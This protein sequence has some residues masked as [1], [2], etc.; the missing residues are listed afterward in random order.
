MLTWTVPTVSS[1]SATSSIHSVNKLKGKRHFA[2]GQDAKRSFLWSRRW[3]DRARRWLMHSIFNMLVR[4]LL[5]NNC[6][7]WRGDREQK[8]KYRLMCHQILSTSLPRN[9]SSRWHMEQNQSSFPRWQWHH[10]FHTSWQSVFW[11]VL[12]EVVHRK[13]LSHSVQ[14]KHHDS[15]T[16]NICPHRNHWHG[17]KTTW[18]DI[19]SNTPIT[20]ISS[21]NGRPP[22]MSTST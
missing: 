14:K 5:Y 17:E 22:E 19:V 7:W 6:G 13:T 3:N 1:F 10:W 9:E 8:E 11:R 20:F 12:H 4:I 21:L 15:R 18:K 2:A 16:R